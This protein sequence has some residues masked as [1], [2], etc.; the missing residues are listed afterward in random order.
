MKERGDPPDGV[1]KIDI[2][3]SATGTNFYAKQGD[4][5]GKKESTNGVYVYVSNDQLLTLM[6]DF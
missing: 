2:C 5:S 3:R 6:Q 1:Y 4:A